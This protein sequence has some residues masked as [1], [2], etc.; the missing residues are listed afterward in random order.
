MSKLKATVKN[1]I[2]KLR[3]IS[4][5]DFFLFK[6][7]VVINRK[8][9]SRFKREHPETVIPPDYFLYETYHLDYESYFRNGTAAANNILNWANQYLSGK[10]RNVLEW[11]CGASRIT[12]PMK[13]VLGNDVLL[14]GCDINPEMIS[15]NSKHF[16]NI[17]YSLINYKPPSVYQDNQFDLIYAISVF[18]HIEFDLHEK[19]LKEIYRILSINGI[20]LFTMQGSLF[21]AKLTGK[22]Q[23]IL[24]I[25]GGYTKMYYKKGHR[26]MSTYN[27][28]NATRRVI[29]NYFQVLELHE[30]AIDKH[31]TGGQDL[32]IVKKVT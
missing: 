18:T 13:K 31:K 1:V 6:L 14:F 19:W 32:W 28:V 11:G 23:E 9:N 8:R 29:E 4:L 24:N 21:Y 25:S 5:L 10:I 7:S 15:F 17:K 26:M 16:N 27:S 12:N 22:E 30:G 2:Y 20:F 3:L